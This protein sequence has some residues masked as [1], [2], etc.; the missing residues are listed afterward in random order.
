MEETNTPLRFSLVIPCRN[1]AGY[2]VR[3]LAPI[4]K[5]D[6]F[7]L[8]RAEVLFVDDGST[9]NS[10]EIAERFGEDLPNFRLLR[11]GAKAGSGCGGARNFA[12]K[13]AKG[14][15]V[16]YIDCDDYL[17]PNALAKID[18][19]ISS[20]KEKDGKDPDV[21]VFPFATFRPPS[22]RRRSGVSNPPHGDIKQI[23]FGPVAPW[24]QVIR[25]EKCLTFPSRIIAEDLSWHYAQFD[26]FDSFAAT[27]GEE[28]LYFYDRTN[29]SAIT[30]TLEWCADNPRTLEQ[31]AYSDELLRGGRNDRWPS[32]F[33]R[34]I[35]EMYD[36]RHALTKPW[37]RE[38]W[39]LRFRALC[40]NLMTGRY[41][42]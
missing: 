42:H 24:A 18:A 39:A 8:S 19:A 6:G 20:A 16:W 26:R 15:Y 40:S 9:D 29:A 23:A 5:Q 10:G 4:A 34:G 28:P 11:T 37:V 31:L 33:L 3:C 22:S 17:A 1:C 7:D 12:L 38:A 14:E 32:D 35:A 36:I 21:C 30:D 27:E 2:V 41:I 25:R 13:D